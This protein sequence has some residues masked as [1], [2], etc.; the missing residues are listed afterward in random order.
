MNVL[1]YISVGVTV[2]EVLLARYM[3]VNKFK[4]KHCIILIYTENSLF[5]ENKFSSFGFR[6]NYF[7]PVK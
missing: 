4:M 2:A 3:V 1:E 7:V 5:H 6:K